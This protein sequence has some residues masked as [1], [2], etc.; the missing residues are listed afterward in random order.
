MLFI[1]LTEVEKVL[2]K[3]V[4]WRSGDARVALGKLTARLGSGKD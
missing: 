1:P 2:W 4:A 3:A